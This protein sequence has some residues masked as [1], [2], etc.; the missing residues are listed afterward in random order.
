LRHRKRDLGA[1][2]V[3]ESDK[4]TADEGLPFAFASA[5]AADN[6]PHRQARAKMRRRDGTEVPAAMAH[7]WRI[8]GAF[9]A[10]DFLGV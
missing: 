2:S 9:V 10:H 6:Q 1:R 4:S 7:F 5:D 3:L 8:G